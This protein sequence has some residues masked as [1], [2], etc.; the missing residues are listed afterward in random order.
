[1]VGEE[2]AQLVLKE[3]VYLSHSPLSPLQATTTLAADAL[4]SRTHCPFQGK[5]R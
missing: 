4:L 5:H 2:G 3:D 1:M